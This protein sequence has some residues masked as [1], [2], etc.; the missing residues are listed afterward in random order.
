MIPGY[1]RAVMGRKSG[2][3]PIQFISAI[4]AITPSVAMPAHQAGDLIIAF[5]MSTSTTQV[6][7]P[8]GGGWTNIHNQSTSNGSIR[9]AY[10]FAASASEVSGIWG[11]SSALGLS[12]YRNATGIGNISNN[13]NTTSTATLDTV[14]PINPPAFF[15]A[16]VAA[17][18]SSAVLGISGTTSRLDIRNAGT[19][20]SL[21]AGDTDGVQENWP[22]TN[23]TLTLS[24]N[25]RW[26]SIVLEILN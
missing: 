12:V 19:G 1:P 6:T 14:T 4:S 15:F 20:I 21:R 16:A 11:N 26:H 23:R 18:A 17:N 8:L 22:S 25:P 5:A 7:I 2:K 9:V 3:F 10:K 13:T 24:A